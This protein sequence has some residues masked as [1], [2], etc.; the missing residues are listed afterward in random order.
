M[1]N[2]TVRLNVIDK[3]DLLATS[4]D[5]EAIDE[6]LEDGEVERYE[7]QF[8]IKAEGMNLSIIVDLSMGENAANNI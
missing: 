1:K 6:E 8:E 2:K 4:I 7:E 5:I 3:E